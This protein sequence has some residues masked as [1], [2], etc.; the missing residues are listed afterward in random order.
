MGESKNMMVYDDVAPNE[1][2]RIYDKGVSGPKHHDSFPEFHYSYKYG[3]ILIPIIEGEESLFT[4]LCHFVDCIWNDTCPRSDGRSGLLVVKIIEAAQKS[5]K[6][7]NNSI[8]IH[9]ESE[10]R[11]SVV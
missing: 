3:D 4:E 5:L 2:I 8:V 9:Q 10:R 1:K 11:I 7:N 6:S